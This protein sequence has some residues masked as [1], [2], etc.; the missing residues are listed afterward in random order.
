MNNYFLLC[1]YITPIFLFYYV[2]LSFVTFIF[3]FFSPPPPFYFF[4][5]KRVKISFKIHYELVFF[6]VISVAKVYVL[7]NLKIH[8]I[9][10]ILH[11]D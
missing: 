2:Y 1:F 8:L 7:T 5:K 4:E 11:S 6:T 3:Y 10:D 9:L